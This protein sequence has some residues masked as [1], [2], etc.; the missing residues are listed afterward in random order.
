MKLGGGSLKGGAFERLICK[1]LSQWI[2]REEFENESIFR[3]SSL[4]GGSHT[5]SIKKG[6][7]FYK[8]QSGDI[9]A[10][11]PRANDFIGNV[12]LELK[13]RADINLY[14]L[15]FDKA[16]K[17]ENIMSWWREHKRLA[18]NIGKMPMVIARQN[19]YKDIVLVPQEFLRVYNEKAFF[20]VGSVA[21]FNKI[22][23]ELLFLSDFLDMT[24][25]IALSAA[26]I[27]NITERG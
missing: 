10:A 25:E 26:Q 16:P 1:E 23:A 18:H 13:H 8:A 2:L 12:S 27:Y 4:S 9:S 24:Y 14:S 6:K 17:S 7:N 20:T 21:T 19:R 3:R 5:N 22:D 11:D 15:I